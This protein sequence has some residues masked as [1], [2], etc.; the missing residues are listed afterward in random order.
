M[1]DSNAAQSP[2]PS[3]SPSPSPPP[4]PTPNPIL[5]PLCQQDLSDTTMIEHVTLTHPLTLSVWLATAFPID[6]DPVYERVTSLIRDAMSHSHSYLLSNSN[7]SLG[8]GYYEDGDMIDDWEDLLGYGRDFDEE[9][10]GGGSYEYYTQL[11]DW[12]GDQ[13]AGVPDIDAAAPIV[14]PNDC[15]QSCPICLD[16]QFEEKEEATWR[17]IRKCNHV[18][19][20]PCL[21]HWLAKKS[22]CPLCKESASA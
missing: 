3:P 22:W 11:C 10:G 19:C 16:T 21:E 12:I 15:E 20:A 6:N 1:N 8:L 13:D 9:A 17:A 14:C 18:F 2:N 7:L 4:M 5:C